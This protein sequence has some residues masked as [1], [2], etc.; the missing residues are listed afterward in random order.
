MPQR[1]SFAVRERLSDIGA[2][3]IDINISGRYHD[4]SHAG[5][6]LR[7]LK[8]FEKAAIEY[9]L[10]NSADLTRSNTTGAMLSPD[11]A[12]LL[13]LK[14]ILEESADWYL[15]MAESM[16]SLTADEYILTFGL[17][18]I[19][20]SL[21]KSTRIVRAAYNKRAPELCGRVPQFR[22][23]D[24]NDS[25]SAIAVIGMACR[26]PGAENVAEYWQ[27]LKEARSMV[28][29]LPPSRFGTNENIQNRTKQ[30]FWGNYLND[31]SS[32][33]HS[34]FKKSPREAQ[35]MDPQQRLLLEVTYEALESSGYF[36]DA[37]RT[38]EIGCYIGACTSDYDFNTLS[39]K[40]SAFSAI[41]TLRSFLSGKLSHYFGWSAPSLV[42]DTACSSSAVAIHTACTALRTRQ[43]AQAVA[44]GV[45][46]MA[47]PYWHNNF[48]AAH[49]LS[50]SGASKP[51]DAA[52]DGYC[53]GEGAGI[54]VLKRLDDAIEAGD[55]VLGIIAASAINQ[56][57]N[58]VPI[59]V[60]YTTSQASL[61]SRVLHQASVSATE[62][63]FV[64]AHGTG[65]PVG[66]PIEMESIR[67]V[68]GS[69]SR[70]TPLIV[71]SAKGNI[72]HLEGASGVVALIKA[73]LQ[74]QNRL[75]PRQASFKSL[76]PN[77]KDLEQS[78]IV[79]PTKNEI[80]NATRLVACV[81][82][83]GAAGSNAAMIVLEGPQFE[84]SQGG[85][86]PMHEDE[87]H[88]TQSYPLR[89]A[90]SS[91]GS[92]YA[93]CEALVRRCDH[94][95]TLSVMQPTNITKGIARAMAAR[96]NEDLSFSHALTYR[97]VE[98][99]QSQ[100]QHL[101]GR[102][103][104]IQVRDRKSKP[105]PSP[106]VLC[107]G[108]QTSDRVSLD[109][110]LWQNCKLLQDHLNHCDSLITLLGYP[111][112]YPGI[113]GLG[114]AP[115]VVS[116]HAMLFALQ[117]SSAR[118]WMDAGLK[119]D[120]LLGHSFGQL[121]ALC[122]SGQLSLHDGLKLV[123]GRAAIMKTSWGPERGVMTLVECSKDMILLIQENMSKE[124][125]TLEV[126]C[127]NG[128][129]SYVLVC[130]K[131]SAAIL[132]HKLSQQE[133]RFKRLGVPYGF[134]SVFTEPILE[135]L[136][137]VAER[138]EFKEATVSLETC[139]EL[140]SWST[141]SADLI[142]RHTREPVYFDQAVQ[143][144]HQKLG[145]STWIE[146]GS[147]S[148]ITTMVRRILEGR[149]FKYQS[150]IP[151]NLGK[152][153]AEELL[154]DAT[155]TLWK[156]GHAMQYWILYRPKNATAP[157]IWLPPYAW[158]KSQHW[159]DLLAPTTKSL[160][161]TSEPVAIP[162]KPVELISLTSSK[163]SDYQFT[164]DTRHKDFEIIIDGVTAKG[165]AVYPISIW[166]QL[167]VR[168]MIV[169]GEDG[170]DMSLSF[171]KSIFHRTEEALQPTSMDITRLDN[172]SFKFVISLASH[173]KIL[174]EGGCNFNMDAESL[175]TSF[176]RYEKLIGKDKLPSI[177]EHNARKAIYG[178][179]IYDNFPAHAQWTLQYQGLRSVSM[180]DC[181]VAAKLSIP[182]V[183]N[184]SDTSTIFAAILENMSQMVSLHLY[185]QMGI[186]HDVQSFCAEIEQFQLQR[187]RLSRSQ[188][189][190]LQMLGISNLAGAGIFAY[191]IFVFDAANNLVMMCL[192]V[193]FKA[194]NAEKSIE[195]SSKHQVL[196]T[197]AVEP[198]HNI[199]VQNSCQPLPTLKE[200]EE[201][202][203]NGKT[204]IY[205]AICQLLKD[206]ADVAKEDVFGKASL[207]DL[208]I[209]SLMMIEVITELSSLYHLDLPIEELERLTDID[210][211]VQYLDS[212]INRGFCDEVGESSTDNSN[213]QNTSATPCTSRASS[214]SQSG[215]S[216]RVDSRHVDVDGRPETQESNR[217]VLAEDGADVQKVFESIKY[218]FELCAEQT[219]FRSFWSSIYPH[220]M[221]LV[222]TYVAEAYQK[223][224]CD[225]AVIGPAEQ[226][227]AIDALPKH[228]KLVTQ[229]EN[230]LIE[231]GWAERTSASILI[232]TAK[233]LDLVPST[234][235]FEES[236]RRFPL[237]ALD[238]RV[239]RVTGEHLAECLTGR[240]DPLALLFG[241]ADNRKLLADFY[242]NS[243]GLKATTIL[244]GAFIKTAA[245]IGPQ[246]CP[247]EILEIGAGTGGTTGYLLG[248]LSSLGIPF[249][250]VFSDISQ[251]LVSQ[252]KRRFS[253][254]YPQLDFKTY[255]CN[256]PPSP[257]MTAKYDIIISTN[258]IHATANITKATSNILPML[259][260]KGV[261]CVSECTK[262]IFWFDLVFGLL[263]GWWL[264][265][266]GRKHALTD[267]S[268]WDQSLRA[269]GFKHVSW[270]D[271]D[272]EEAKTFR[273]I[274]AFK[275]GGSLPAPMK[276]VETTPS[277]PVLKRAG[278]PFKEIPW[279]QVGLL[280]LSVDIYL[281][282]K[283]DGP[284]VKRPIGEPTL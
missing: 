253:K 248:V 196:D 270:S 232:R 190:N 207:D 264:F 239:L 284:E 172:Q 249:K 116:L 141:I 106:V 222:G 90:A 169:L 123:I 113:F 80:L 283:P 255:D 174:A 151:L 158:Q 92:F 112:I 101:V 25:S 119:V 199:V 149:N 210:S 267:V 278:I 115:D 99:L 233:P 272:N 30:R 162:T 223:L 195:P 57:E 82:N 257:D 229:L 23:V 206:L 140:S 189:G 69:P 12:T 176:V 252:A 6:A 168:S 192:G 181:Y 254:Q 60:P 14:C 83:Y 281:P 205:N 24:S 164:I 64:E 29:D 48:S 209:D 107:F 219:G 200:P 220:Q 50:P 166:Y 39:Q 161:M 78:N 251:S 211:L 77:I 104:A 221:G 237:Y 16:A 159:L 266:D 11:R 97:S 7:I 160:E 13:S 146:A 194:S 31:I 130:D 134:H 73:I 191:D 217:P 19:P 155:M 87:I 180:V 213:S 135:E 94:L 37:D 218:G 260:S 165:H 186:C 67:Q 259:R 142:V 214:T 183:E 70:T 93:Y 85:G 241:S 273:L 263:E 126:T 3:S 110:S 271:G 131:P 282:K 34:F 224:G 58:C 231:R 153:K 268:F 62:V 36:A 45:N 86:L 59:T 38:D 258:C 256:D 88:G 227:P 265:E 269:A 152:K 98:D 17:D 157:P 143:R 46:I 66:D 54:V 175:E 177:F 261:L 216:E 4:S 204:E 173:G 276:V 230:I 72:G 148:G 133:I 250:Y 111:S 55:N 279:K 247:L 28:T 108:G 170:L 150:C 41:G 52:A 79:V 91:E 277:R 144:I 280:T 1:D 182:E 109:R 121:T 100:L 118:A 235:Q 120:T 225:L 18:S 139:S 163:D 65:T 43:C 47:H 187:E 212:K 81:N 201:P 117:Y 128:P 102:Q 203:A 75:A 10:L 21:T 156:G 53:R 2:S 185:H 71:S 138:L 179:I 137:E 184:L 208:G 8:S 244:L 42:I 198:G 154:L 105:E 35:S 234:V 125:V 228:N 68:F 246:D 26:V 96:Y 89:I 56:N 202:N 76:N 167:V 145:P 9:D 245:T 188:L 44:G 114:N 240:K 63:C 33:D 51:F 226:L 122:V 22:P 15:T 243:I 49:F 74:M 274:C 136:R 262:N 40:P 129:L 84:I 197:G 193:K 242:A 95:S 178:S 20:Q 215:L 61:Y 147:D 32:F 236:L 238:T 103:I 127:H 124:G 132:E 171:S 27:L 5:V 275:S